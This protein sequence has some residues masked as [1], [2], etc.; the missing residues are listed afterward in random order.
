[1]APRRRSRRDQVA[2]VAA[3]LTMQLVGMVVLGFSV[4]AGSDFCM[5]TNSCSAG[6]PVVGAV[7]AAIGVAMLYGGFVAGA[8]TAKLERPLLSGLLA[9]VAGWGGG[10]LVSMLAGRRPLVGVVFVVGAVFV[11]VAGRRVPALAATAAATIVMALKETSSRGASNGLVA[12]TLMVL[13]ALVVLGPQGQPSSKAAD[14]AP[15]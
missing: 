13:V 9:F 4:L 6:S 1:M 11:L 15:T 7:V 5:E 12:M 3:V 2:A 14:R 8:R 10:V